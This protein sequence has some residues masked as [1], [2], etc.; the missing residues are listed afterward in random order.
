MAV[1]LNNFSLGTSRSPGGYEASI[2][3]NG[4]NYPDIKTSALLHKSINFGAY[5]TPNT[6]ISVPFACYEKYLQELTVVTNTAAPR[7][8]LRIPMDMTSNGP[9]PL[10]NVVGQ[11]SDCH[12][13]CR[14]AEA[15]PCVPGQIVNDQSANYL[16]LLGTERL[17]RKPRRYYTRL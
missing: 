8:G 7:T 14:A 10:L 4:L 15:V 12:I 6:N 5:L 3:R 2:I 13:D 1:V 11:P 9:K 17:G 16:S